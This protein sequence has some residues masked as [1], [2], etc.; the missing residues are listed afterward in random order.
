M[1][2]FLLFT[3]YWEIQ[4]SVTQMN[5][6]N[7]DNFAAGLTPTQQKWISGLFLW[8]LIKN[9]RTINHC[10]KFL[11]I[12]IVTATTHIMMVLPPIFYS[13]VTTQFKL[14]ISYDLNYIHWRAFFTIFVLALY[15]TLDQ[16]SRIQRQFPSSWSGTDFRVTHDFTE[17]FFSTYTQLQDFS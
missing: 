7:W 16:Q 11:L 3:T 5:D 1:L 2:A 12:Q 10:Q 9:F 15:T 13:K 14:L 6:A 4:Q 8:L 17:N